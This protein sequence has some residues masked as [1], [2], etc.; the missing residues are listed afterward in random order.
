[1]SKMKTALTHLP[2]SISRT[3]VK[4]TRH[5]VC[6][7][8]AI[9]LV[10]TPMRAQRLS[11]MPMP[12]AMEG[13]TTLRADA[14]TYVL[15]QDLPSQAGAV[16]AQRPLDLRRDFTLAFEIYL[17][18]KEDLREGADGMAFVLRAQPNG[19]G[20]NG[21]GLGLMGLQPSLSVEFD[22]YTN[23]DYGDPWG[24]HIALLVSDGNSTRGHEAYTMV[25]QMED[26]HF[27]DVDITWKAASQTLAVHFDGHLA[28]KQSED[29][30][31]TLFEGQHAVYWGWTAAT[32]DLSNLQQMRLRKAGAHQPLEAAT[33][34]P[35][36]MDEMPFLPSPEPKIPD[37]HVGEATNPDDELAA[38]QSTPSVNGSLLSVDGPALGVSPNPSDGRIRVQLTGAEVGSDRYF[39]LRV[40]D[41]AGH[42]CY[43][44]GLAWSKGIG[45]QEID[46]SALSAGLYTII[47]EDAADCYSVKMV[48][49]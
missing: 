25:R 12:V 24:D 19:L 41:N 48:K 37:E 30:S 6:L 8:A 46:L 26:G 11:R 22:T 34:I 38:R 36:D 14:K 29:F 10:A 32:G 42:V 4:A 2:R 13:T 33:T 18:G 21:R 40:L 20:A 27:H 1:M 23:G 45:S 3:A 43:I 15:T 5:A 7:V 47:A 35:S 49:R 39:T 17:G 31:A 44:G 9:G 28:A 16:W